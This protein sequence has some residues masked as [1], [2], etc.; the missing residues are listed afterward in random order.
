MEFEAG[1]CAFTQQ[2]QHKLVILN[3][4]QNLPA[5]SQKYTMD[6]WSSASLIKGFKKSTTVLRVG[7][8][9]WRAP[10]GWRECRIH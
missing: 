7:P 6:V 4:F 2:T 1:C 5:L 3:L 8:A 9:E 10:W